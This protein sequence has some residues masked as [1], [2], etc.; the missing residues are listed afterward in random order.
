MSGRSLS[1]MVVAAACAVLV[2]PAAPAGQAP[3]A[4]PDAIRP[5]LA[6]ESVSFLLENARIVDG[7]GAP[8]REGQSLLIENGRITTVGPRGEI[9]APPGAERIDLTGHTILPGLVMMHEHMSYMSGV[10]EPCRQPPAVRS[11]NSATSIRTACRNC[12]LRWA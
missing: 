4:A 8:A 2:V 5:F 9:A 11:S 10:A 12:S 6:S 7:T 1:L 3:A